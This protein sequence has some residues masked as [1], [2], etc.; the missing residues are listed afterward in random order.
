[1][2]TLNQI[3]E[4]INAQ[5]KNENGRW[6]PPWE[7]KEM[8]QKHFDNVR[9]SSCDGIYFFISKADMPEPSYIKPENMLVLVEAAREKVNVTLRWERPKTK[10]SIT[11]LML[12][13]SNGGDTPEHITKQYLQ[14]AECMRNSE[15]ESEKQDFIKVTDFLKK[16]G[17]TIE[18]F[19]AISEIYER[20]KYRWD[21]IADKNTI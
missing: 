17:V 20:R 8:L 1:M 12:R 15:R 16:S 6:I 3:I 18:E 7:V 21:N 4:S 13:T 9:I 11:S 10:M 14:Q 19:A 2:S 5:I